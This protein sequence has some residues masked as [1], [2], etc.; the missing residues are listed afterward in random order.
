MADNKKS[1]LMDTNA[2]LSSDLLDLIMSYPCAEDT[3]NDRNFLN[4]LLN[5]I[6]DPLFIK[7][8]HGVY[9]GGNSHF[10]RFL[11]KS[12]DDVIG[13][14]VYDFFEEDFASSCNAVDKCLIN[15]PGTR[16]YETRLRFPDGKDHNVVI[17]RSAFTDND[18]NPAGIIGILKDVT[19]LRDKEAL[20]KTSEEKFEKVFRIIP[21]P[22]VISRLEDGKIIDFNNS[23][24]NLFK[25]KLKGE[26]RPLTEQDK[27]WEDSGK[28]L[29]FINLILKDGFVENYYAD[30]LTRDGRTLKILISGSLYYIHKKPHVLAV[31]RDISELYEIRDDLEIARKKYQ[32]IFENAGTGLIVADA[33]LKIKLSNTHLRK[34]LG[35]LPEEIDG[36]LF[37]SDIVDDTEKERIEEFRRKR[38]KDMS[39]LPLSHDLIL[40]SAKGERIY[41]HIGVSHMPGLDRIL[42][43]MAD[44]SERISAER[45]LAESEKFNK[46]LINNLP[47]YIV[48]YDINGKVIYINPSGSKAIGYFRKDL[49]GRSLTDYIHPDDRGLAKKMLN[50][51]LSDSLKGEYEIRLISGSGDVII[52]N[53]RGRLIEFD[54]KPAV[55]LV[56]N[57]ITKRK[58]L[59]RNLEMKAEEFRLLS[60]SKALAN[61]KL[62]LLSNITR[63][64]ILNQITVLSA[65]E[66][67]VQESVEM[68]DPDT[69]LKY[70][71]KASVATEKI[72]GQIQFTKYYQDIGIDAPEWQNVSGVISEVN[73]KEFFPPG[74]VGIPDGSIEIFADRMLERVFYTL[75]DNSMRHGLNLTAINVRY[76]FFEKELLIFIEDDGGGIPPEK[77]IK[78]FDVGYGSNTGFGLFLAREILELSG[79]S[80]HENGVYGEGARFEILVPSGNWRFCRD[81][82]PSEKSGKYEVDL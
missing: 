61:K 42:M 50:L 16:E 63:H 4:L 35:Y 47:D 11:G 80:I 70:L 69:A 19:E 20:I 1:G 57:D 59:E 45:A 12:R 30:F 2:G 44:I 66:E 26:I 65:Y 81:E 23:F 52:V 75:F 9:T 41:T 53:I 34:M 31:L 72:S 58:E 13:H 56:L 46:D 24:E 40:K 49:V 15:S 22:V 21:D 54:K 38:M 33:D 51:R 18:G 8:I 62:N 10:F 28:R 43:S 74:L 64:D 79:I 73:E 67:L 78:I 37:L 76:E 5:S 39:V 6:P 7:D 48:I 32:A 27:L 68:N 36:K 25:Y 55:M 14:L 82:V 60:E 3:D 29:E 71:N 77:K 17:L